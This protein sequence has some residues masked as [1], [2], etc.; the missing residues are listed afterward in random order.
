MCLIVSHPSSPCGSDLSLRHPGSQAFIAYN[1]LSVCSYGSDPLAA[2]LGVMF[3]NRYVVLPYPFPPTMR[4]ALA[5]LCPSLKRAWEADVFFRRLGTTHRNPLTTLSPT[6][7]LRFLVLIRMHV[8]IQHLPL[9]RKAH[10]RLLRSSMRWCLL[11]TSS[12][13]LLSLISLS[14]HG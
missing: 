10:R 8:E 1:P 9:V 13:Q 4:H 7:R 12:G 5:R 11:G 2:S 3:R 6:S 14:D